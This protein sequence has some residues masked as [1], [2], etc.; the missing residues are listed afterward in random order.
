MKKL[1][2]AIGSIALN[3]AVSAN[4]AHAEDSEMIKR[5]MR[6]AS[7][8]AQIGEIR[9]DKTIDSGKCKF[10]TFNPY[11]FGPAPQTDVL[12]TCPVKPGR[13]EANGTVPRERS[14][15]VIVP[16]GPNPNIQLIFNTSSAN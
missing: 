10:E 3:Y 7:V 11:N 4:F 5:V 14:L 9:S 1:L 15:H 2:I 16:D 8:R 6:Y 13:M 12:F